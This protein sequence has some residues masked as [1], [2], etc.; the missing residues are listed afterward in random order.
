[1]DIASKI[2]A[3]EVDIEVVKDKVKQ[4]TIKIELS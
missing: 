2:A 4:G 1:V 3:G